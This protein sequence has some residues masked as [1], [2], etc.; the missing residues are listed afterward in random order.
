MSDAFTLKEISTR[1]RTCTVAVFT[2]LV[3]ASLA[4]A[5]HAFDLTGHWTGKWNCKGFDRTKFTSSEKSSTLAI[6]QV[7]P[8]F[9]ANIDGI[10]G[11]FYNVTPLTDA[12][13]P[14]KGE[15]VLLACPT[16][17]PL[18]S[19]DAEIIR[20]AVKTKNG[21]VNATLKGTS[22]FA[23]DAPEVGTCKYSYK[24]I[25]ISDPAVAGCF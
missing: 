11:F 7:G 10:T 22:V 6:T 4:P 15:A 20:A 5:A 25:D 17:N 24:R 3:T 12:A 8:A 16:A 2:L 14:E 21:T 1:T 19:G 23:N 18:G 9:A 13:K